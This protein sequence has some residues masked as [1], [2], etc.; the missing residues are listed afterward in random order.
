[1]R[2]FAGTTILTGGCLKLSN[3]RESQHR[4]PAERPDARKEPDVQRM[5]HEFADVMVAAG[6]IPDGAS[7]LDFF[8]ELVARVT[9]QPDDL[10]TIN[11]TQDSAVDRWIRE[12]G[13]PTRVQAS[14]LNALDGAALSVPDLADR[15]TDGDASSLYRAG[16]KSALVSSGLIKH[17]HGVGYYRPDRPPREAASDAKAKRSHREGA[18]DAYAPSQP[19]VIDRDADV[20]VYRRGQYFRGYIE[21]ICFEADKTACQPNGR[22]TVHYGDV[23]ACIRITRPGISEN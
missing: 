15:C 7:K 2:L 9:A 5:I 1:M 23:Y 14:I 20:L 12:N 22:P 8:A 13:P 21:S 10:R 18:D 6:A 17:K 4:A 19:A 3:D 16:L 11:T